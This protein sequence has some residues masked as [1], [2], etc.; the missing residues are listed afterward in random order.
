[1]ALNWLDY[2]EEQNRLSLVQY[3]PY[4]LNLLERSIDI[5]ELIRC[6][7]SFRIPDK[8]IE[9]LINCDNNDISCKSVSFSLIY[10]ATRRL[11][12]ARKM[13]LAGYHQG[14]LGSLRDMIECLYYSDICRQ[15][16]SRSKRWLKFGYLDK[17][18]N[19]NIHPAIEKARIGELWKL[20]SKAGVHP[21]FGGIFL[22][23]SMIIP[24]MGEFRGVKYTLTEEWRESSARRNRET[25]E[26]IIMWIAIIVH[27]H[28]IV[29]LDDLYGDIYYQ[30]PEIKL[31]MEAYEDIYHNL[32]EGKLK[33]NKIF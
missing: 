23:T 29:Y 27:D 2:F 18:S 25:I 3:F 5:V 12:A 26:T 11:F 24:S 1:M 14:A 21:C 30:N 15:S 9:D 8:T 19:L 31:K 33:N 7:L 6:E 28:F 10:M 20:L 4:E 32:A 13:L 17:P 16:I 22:E